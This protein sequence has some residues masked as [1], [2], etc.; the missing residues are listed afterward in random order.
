VS[1][2]R[3]LI[4]ALDL[5]VATCSAVNAVRGAGERLDNVDVL[6][7]FAFEAFAAAVS[8]AVTHGAHAQIK[9]VRASDLGQ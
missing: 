8:V 7:G 2:D 5:H 3:L 6:A 1:A 4:A 9:L